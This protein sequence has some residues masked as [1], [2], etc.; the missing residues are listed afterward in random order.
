LEQRVGHPAGL[1]EGSALRREAP[2]AMPPL[3]FAGR[4]VPRAADGVRR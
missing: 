3:R 1:A 4:A 2:E